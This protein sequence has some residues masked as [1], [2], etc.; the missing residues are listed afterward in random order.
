MG[1]VLEAIFGSRSA[2]QVL[3]FLEAYGS[4]HASRIAST[5]EVPLNP[6]YLQLRRLETNGV[7]VSSTVGRTRVFTFNDRN[8]SVRHLREFLSAELDSLSEEETKKYFRQRQRPRRT[9]KR[10]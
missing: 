3:M 4:G 7:L 8:P 6:I 2:S 9:G 10:L 1:P 5:F